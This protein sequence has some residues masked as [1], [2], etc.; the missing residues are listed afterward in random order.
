MKRCA[1][2]SS[3]IRAGTSV[4]GASSGLGGTRRSKELVAP[5]KVSG[6]K[7]SEGRLEMSVVVKIGSERS[8][9]L[10]VASDRRSSSAATSC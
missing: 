8:K 6:D 7:G 1:H 3:R 2:S 10:S 5:V 4:P 9:P